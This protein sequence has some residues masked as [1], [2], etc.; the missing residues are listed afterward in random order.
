MSD[1]RTLA[2]R[3]EPPP[4]VSELAS[5]IKTML[6]NGKNLTDQEAIAGA[7]YG[8][9]HGLDVFKQ[10]FYIVPGRGIYPGYR[11]EMRL[12]EARTYYTQTRPLRADEAAEH[13]IQA[14]DTARIV[15]LYQPDLMAR[16]RTMGIPYQPIAGLG[17][18]RKAEKGS[19]G[20]PTGRSWAWK[21][22]QRALKDAMRHMQG[23]ADILDE[24]AEMRLD[25]AEQAAE[26][27]AATVRRLT[28][29]EQQATL[30]ANVN[31][32]RGAPE[33]N[34]FD[35][36]RQEADAP[37]DAEEDIEDA[38]FA[39]I[40]SAT[41]ERANTPAAQI[42]FRLRDLGNND[43][44][45]IDEATSKKLWG[46]LSSLTSRNEARSKALVKLVYGVEHSDKLTLGQANT[47][48]GWIS[49]RPTKDTNGKIIEW[50]P[51]GPALTAGEYKILFPP[52]PELFSEG[53]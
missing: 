53:E 23:G 13:E 26:T 15:E 2:L 6:P 49:S 38:E 48:I 33:D 20:P 46:N 25:A 30:K 34:P 21:A 35:D 22:E 17:I 11:G 12:Q 7:M 8:K 45:P 18:V 1:D 4:D 3:A 52:E 31:A 39:A 40:P 16:M 5:L 36:D 28:P 44:R 9:A 24:T 29:A 42:I 10:E 27:V 51:G 32:M 43:A 47:L 41:E 14:G 50:V 37:E 19:A